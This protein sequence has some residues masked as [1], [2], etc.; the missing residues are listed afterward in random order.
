LK[1]SAKKSERDK[2][3]WNLWE[4]WLIFYYSNIYHETISVCVTTSFQASENSEGFIISGLAQ[5]E[6][7]RFVNFG[8]LIKMRIVNTGVH[9]IALLLLIV[10]PPNL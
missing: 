6:E 8:L 3:H 7:P 5:A 4:D 2:R 10:L 9:K 1:I